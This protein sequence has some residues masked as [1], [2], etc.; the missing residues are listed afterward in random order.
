LGEHKQG[1]ESIKL[2]GHLRSQ[3][4][5]LAY[6]PGYTF[7]KCLDTKGKLIQGS[8][9]TIPTK[10]YLYCGNFEYSFPAHFS[11]TKFFQA[12]LWWLGQELSDFLNLELQVIYPTPKVPPAPSCGGGC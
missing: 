11:S 9:I 2:S 8:T 3:I 1:H 10:L 4:E 6:N 5:I 7:D 12:E